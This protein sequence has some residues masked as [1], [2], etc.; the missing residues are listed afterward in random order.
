MLFSYRFLLGVNGRNTA[1]C[2][3]LKWREFEG[4]WVAQSFEHL[5]TDLNSGL[6]LRVVE[7]T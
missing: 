3:V 6:D 1:F 4:T 7:P 2:F 5:T